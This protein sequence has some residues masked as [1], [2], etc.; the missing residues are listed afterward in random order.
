M[1]RAAGAGCAFGRDRLHQRGGWQVWAH[2]H[3]CCTATALACLVFPYPCA[4]PCE[5]LLRCRVCGRRYGLEL[6]L[7]TTPTT[8]RD[9][10]NTIAQR[11]QGFLYLVSVTG[12]FGFFLTPD[13]ATGSAQTAY[14]GPAYLSGSARIQAWHSRHAQSSFESQRMPCLRKQPCA[15]RRDRLERHHGGPS[16]GPYTAAAGSFQRASGCGLWGV[17]PQAGGAPCL[18]LHPLHCLQCA[19][20]YGLPTQLQQHR[21]LHTAAAGPNQPEMRAQACMPCAA[22]AAVCKPP[23]PPC[24]TAVARIFQAAPAADTEDAIDC[25][26]SSWWSGG[27][28]VL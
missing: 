20:Y 7:L 4:H 26:Q 21:C 6:V 14:V 18:C 10:A 5:H 16:S 27:L 17:W 15:C 9:R 13:F 8:P 3:D 24:T 2:W 28:R 1:R 22:C 11:T 19:S 12:M 25:R 23:C